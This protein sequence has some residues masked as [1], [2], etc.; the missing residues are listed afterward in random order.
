M[1]SLFQTSGFAVLILSLWSSSLA[2]AQT[3]NI[4]DIPL[5]ANQKTTITIEKGRTG[6]DI[7]GTI[8]QPPNETLE[9]TAEIEGESAP[10]LKKAK[11]NWKTACEE[12]KKEVKDLNKGNVILM[13]NCNSNKCVP[14]STAL[15]VCRSTG[16]YKIRVKAQ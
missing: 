8:T 5:D 16:S 9:G 15:T 7:L 14:E 11:A 12:W 3:A 13:I 10:L 6:D 1:K 4:K 2:F